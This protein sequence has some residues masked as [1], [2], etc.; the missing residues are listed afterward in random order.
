MKWIG[1]KFAIN[2][3]RAENPNKTIHIIR[4]PPSQL[5]ILIGPNSP[6]VVLNSISV[7]FW[8]QFISN[9]SSLLFQNIF[10]S[11]FWFFNILF[12]LIFEVIKQIKFY[13]LYMEV[14]NL[15]MKNLLRKKKGS[16]TYV[17]LPLSFSLTDAFQTNISCWLNDIL[18]KR[19]V[20]LESW[21][22]E[23]WWKTFNVGIFIIS[24]SQF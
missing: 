2:V 10:P 1:I 20:F 13:V 23:I 19:K 15:R 16:A 18:I 17:L 7:K 22:R 24:W 14:V 9:I 21:D 11:C 12:L 4:I 5:N 6:L 3:I 8:V